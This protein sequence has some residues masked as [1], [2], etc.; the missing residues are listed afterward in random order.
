M[1]LLKVPKY[2]SKINLNYF[3]PIFF[4]FFLQWL[5]LLPDVCLCT[6]SGER[7]AIF[8]FTG[9]KELTK[10]NSGLVSNKIILLFWV[11][12]FFISVDRIWLGNVF[13]CLLSPAF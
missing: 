6:M 13:S 12:C 2:C 8:V 7:E 4:F 10:Q 5:L 11:L 1:N 9:V 3:E